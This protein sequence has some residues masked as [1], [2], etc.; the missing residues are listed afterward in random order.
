MLSAIFAHP[1]SISPA[2][3]LV[4]LACLV[5]VVAFASPAF[6]KSCYSAAEL[7]AEQGLRIH[8]ELM[9]I[10]LN[11][12][13]AKGNTTNL[14][15]KYEEFTQRHE[16]MLGRYEDTI[17]EVFRREG[18]AN[19]E[20]ALNDFRTALANRI[21]KESVRLQTNV[22][23]KSYGPLVTRAHAMNEAALRTWAQTVFEGYPLSR[24]VCAGVEIRRQASR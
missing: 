7:E 20:P 3:R 12:Q 9:V 19:P 24:P 10:A 18:V 14:Y 21:A 13:A 4:A 6:A 23:C 17:M 2:S 1:S 22:F 15:Q 8:S 5:V 11:C 16:A